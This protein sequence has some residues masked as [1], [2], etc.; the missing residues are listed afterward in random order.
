MKK[1]IINK[2]Q[3][4]NNI[5][6]TTH[7][8]P[9]PDGLSSILACGMVLKQWGKKFSIVTHKDVLPRYNFLPGVKS[10]KAYKDT[11]KPIYDCVVVCDCGDLARVG[12]VQLLIGK[13]ATVINIDHHIT[14]D[15]FGVINEVLPKASSTAEVMYEIFCGAPVVFSKNMAMLLY[16]GIVADTGSFRFDNTSV[17]T[18]QIV[19][20]LM[21]Y[22]FSVTKVYKQLYDT[23]S[24][25]DADAFL[26]LITRY[27]SHFKGKILTLMLSKAALKKFSDYFDLRDAVFRFLCSITGVE[28][29][30]IFTQHSKNETRVNFR[31]TGAVDVARL[32]NLYAGGG[33]QKA[34]GCMVES[35][36]SAAKIKVLKELRKAL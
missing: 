34:S 2:L 21:Q 28:A 16:A 12:L 9:D 23:I 1:R 25:S 6:L 17:R 31:S 8:N 30:A 14:N 3:K 15:Y 13:D 18:H 7:V 27:E 11:M 36:L 22:K 26:K 24:L 5:L 4:A 33:H 32:A 20:E 10:I 35:D 29:I 19:A